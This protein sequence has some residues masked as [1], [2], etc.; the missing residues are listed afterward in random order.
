[1]TVLNRKLVRKEIA[2]ALKLDATVTGLVADIY[3]YQKG[4]LGGQSPVIEVLSGPIRRKIAGMGAKR[5]D[6]AFDLEI[7]I[8]VYDGDDNNP[9]T[10]EQRDDAV[11]D[12]E[13]ALGAWCATHQ[14]GTYYRALRYTD[15]GAKPTEPMIIKMLDGNPYRLEVVHVPV[16]APD[17]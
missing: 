9:L 2:A 5:Y 16:E 4:R 7:H 10:E 12:I 11:D 1:M 13:T 14:S 3:H 17:L 8:L 6:N 15:D